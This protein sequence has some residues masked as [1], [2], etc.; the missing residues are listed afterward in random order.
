[1]I[2]DPSKVNLCEK[3]IEEYLYRN[4]E[5]VIFDGRQVKR[6]VKRQ[7]SVPSGI[8]DLIGLTHDDD[9]VV[10]E[11]KNVAI[12]ASAL[13]QVSRYTFD[14]LNVFQRIIDRRRETED[15][16]PWYVHMLVIGKSIDTKT[17]LE[18]EALNINIVTFN[19]RLSLD[20][21]PVKWRDDFINERIG[22]WDDL[23][24]DSDFLRILQEYQENKRRN[25]IQISLA[26]A[27]SQLQENGDISQDEV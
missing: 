17:M 11:V 27:L 12:D 15:V 25:D 7:Y 18:A 3:D 19:V 8:I 10:V 5:S 1:M 24:S 2:I 16:E 14:V 20:I 22:K 23:L 4:P 9:Y 21:N 26:S 6:W 13:A